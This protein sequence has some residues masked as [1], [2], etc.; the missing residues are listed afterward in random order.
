MDQMRS[1]DVIEMIEADGWF[2]VAVKGE[3]ITSSNIQP[4]KDG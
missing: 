3:V 1:R 2:E 4:K